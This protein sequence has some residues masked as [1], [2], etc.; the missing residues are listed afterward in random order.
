M[1]T[2]SKILIGASLLAIGAGGVA[3]ARGPMGGCGP[4]GGPMGGPMRGAMVEQMFQKLDADKNGAV[5]REEAMKL[6]DE[7]F[8]AIDANKD[9]VIDKAEA[10]TW[11]GRRAPAAAVQAFLDRHDL[12]GDGKVTKAEFEKPFA[13]IFAVFDRNDDGKVTLEE[14]QRAGPMGMGMGMGFG[15]RHHGWHHGGPG[16]GGPGMGWMQQGGYG[17]M[18]GWGP[19]GGGMMGGPQGGPMSGPMGGQPPMAPQPTPAK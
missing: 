11:I 6:V 19:M 1:K 3:Y 8:A 16:M 14:A 17:P 2:L 7:R 12:D 9:G 10:E 18:G 15:G 13:K 4:M 5:T